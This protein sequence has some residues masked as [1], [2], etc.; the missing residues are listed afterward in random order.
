[1]PEAGPIVR[2]RDS[3]SVVLM[4]IV[5]V[6]EMEVGC[7]EA[8]TVAGL[9]QETTARM[10]VELARRGTARRYPKCSGSLRCFHSR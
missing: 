2:R 3:A 7:S 6:F 1:V 9:A 5:I 10:L 8:V 4:V